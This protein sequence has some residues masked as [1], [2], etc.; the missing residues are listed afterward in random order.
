M[1]TRKIVLEEDTPESE[2]EQMEQFLI[3]RDVHLDSR[4][5]GDDNYFVVEFEDEIDMFAF[6]VATGIAGFT[7][8][9]EGLDDATQT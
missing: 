2:I 6:Q 9:Q 7:L 1:I 8:V 4:F 3:D 5:N